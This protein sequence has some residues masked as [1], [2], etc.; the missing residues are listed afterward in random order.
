M[1][2]LALAAVVSLSLSLLVLSGVLEP[3]T[4]V[5]G[6][7]FFD[8]CN[9]RQPDANCSRLSHFASGVAIEFRAVGLL[10]ISFTTHSGSDGQYRPSLPPGKYRLIIAGCKSWI[11][12]TNGPPQTV[13]PRVQDDRDRLGYNWVVDANGTCQAG[14]D[15]LL[16]QNAWSA[17]SQPY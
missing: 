15:P 8:A 9:S 16:A 10:P 5:A 3:R 2:A 1:A 11:P 6:W 4:T 7:I 13:V 12:E 14:A 17:A